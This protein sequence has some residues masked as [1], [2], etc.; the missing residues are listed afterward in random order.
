MPHDMIQYLQ[1]EE[2]HKRLYDNF[3]Q[4]TLNATVKQ[5]TDYNTDEGKLLQQHDVDVILEMPDG[6]V[7][8]VS[9]KDRTIDYGDMLIEMY[10]IFPDTP[11][12]M[13]DSEADYIAYYIIE[14][15][16][17]TNVYWVNAHQL[18]DFYFNKLKPLSLENKFDSMIKQYPYSNPKQS[19]TLTISDHTFNATLIQAYNR[20]RCSDTEWYT[21]SI[22]IKYSDL[23]KFGIEIKKLL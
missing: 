1:R 23:Q 6:Q 14:N 10:S 18:K 15:N 2:R 13:E 8:K 3:Y 11:G 17:I 19:I 22:S 16:S 4:S 20:P 9:E 5:R 21:E 7:I 12:W